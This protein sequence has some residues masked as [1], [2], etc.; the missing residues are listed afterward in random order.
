MGSTSLAAL[1]A[2]SV[3]LAVALSACSSTGTFTG[4]LIDPITGQPRGDTKV[5]AKAKSGG[6]AMCQSF[7]AVTAADGTF[8]FPAT[9]ADHTYM[10]TSLD[11]TLILQGD[12][13]FDGGVVVEG[14]RE[15]QAWRAN[16]AEGVYIVSGNTVTE[17]RKSSD[18]YWEP[19]FPDAKDPKNYE[20]VRYAAVM[21]SNVPNVPAGA[22]LVISGEDN[23]KEL[24]LIPLVH[25]VTDVTF[26]HL[27]SGNVYTLTDAWFVGA[28]FTAKK[29]SGP[30]DVERVEVTPDAAKVHE[31]S[32]KSWA[33][34]IL[35]SDAA[36]P[37]R[38]AVVGPEASRMYIVDLGGD[39]P[40]PGAEAAATPEA[41]APEAAKPAGG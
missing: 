39:A 12:L 30:G 16:K 19:V 24:A 22:Q 21:P 6:D 17:L 32:G 2:G 35:E 27:E 23:L 41:A 38:Y 1:G 25:N 11:E 13:K 20:K 29:I 31:L 34:R 8:T 9:C 7:D 3:F 28:K 40:A 4:R 26:P 15:V 14:T 5:M 37:G 33:V 10:V 18:V 36:A